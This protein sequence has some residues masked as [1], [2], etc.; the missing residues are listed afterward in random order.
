MAELLLLG[1]GAAL[2]DGSRE[3]SML[4][5]RGQRPTVLIDCGGNAARWL[6]Q[7]GAP[8]DPVER[9]IVLPGFSGLQPASR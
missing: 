1:A 8:L 3:A 5:S 6:Q 4:A 9:G 7:S 2:D